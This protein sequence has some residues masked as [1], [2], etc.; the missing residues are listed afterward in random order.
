MFDNSRR[1]PK[2]LSAMFARI[3]DDLH[4]G[5]TAGYPCLD[6][7]T[8]TSFSLKTIL[9][10]WVGDYPGQGAASGFAHASCGRF[11]CH[12][13]LHETPTYLPSRALFLHNVDHLPQGHPLRRFLQRDYQEFGPPPLRQ[14]DECVRRARE[15]EEWLREPSDV[16]RNGIRLREDP[17][18]PG[19][20]VHEQCQMRCVGSIAICSIIYCAM[21]HETYY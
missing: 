5:Q 9:L 15:S 2:S 13:C 20:L 6:A 8:G 19:N 3:V 4:L 10:L 16:H 1:K 14:H 12:W 17:G 21:V 11:Q 7:Q 18:F